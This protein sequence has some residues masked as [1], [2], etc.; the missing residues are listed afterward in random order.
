MNWKRWTCTLVMAFF[1]CLFG[2]V[3][4]WGAPAGPGEPGRSATQRAEVPFELYGDHLIVVKGSIGAIENVRVML[5]TGKNPTAISQ[6]IAEQLNL[7]GNRESL[8]MSNGSIEV[9]SVILPSIH[10][11][12][13]HPESIK[14]LVQDF[15]YLERSLGVSIAGI[16]GLDVLR[17]GSFM[18]DYRRKK[19]VFGP[20][21]ACRKT[22][23]F[24]TRL[25]FLTVKVKIQGQEARLLVDSGT[26][27]LLVY[28]KWLK[29]TLEQV[30]TDSDP[31]I[32]TAAGA[33]S[34]RW[35][36]ASEVS[37]GKENLGPQ[38]MIVVDVDPDPHYEFDGL[39]GFTKLGF[40]KVWFDFDGDL[41]GWD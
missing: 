23:P 20:T 7:S 36:R 13:L 34:A 18:I 19:I 3:G 31:L 2:A 41:F 38:I 39:F 8:L 32:S 40:R 15:S 9:Q 28:R 29:R 37:L 6:K 1:G 35:F 21:K 17:T 26:P 4:L 30:R 12:P 11:G 14:A 33:M 22:V 24:E 25:P 5:D 10:V 27:R 16:V